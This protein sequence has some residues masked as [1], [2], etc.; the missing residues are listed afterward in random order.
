MRGE[1]DRPHGEAYFGTRG[2]LIADRIG[3]EIYPEMEPRRGKAAM[4]AMSFTT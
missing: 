4:A 2:T 1:F 3:Y